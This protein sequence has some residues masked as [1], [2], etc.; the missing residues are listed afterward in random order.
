MKNITVDGQEIKNGNKGYEIF[1]FRSNVESVIW[2]LKEGS[3]YSMYLPNS[4]GTLTFMLACVNSGIAV[5]HSVRRLPDN[6]IITVGDYVENYGKILMI[7]IFD[8]Y[9]IA[10]ISEGAHI[11]DIQTVVKINKPESVNPRIS[12]GLK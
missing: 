2:E 11:L 6:E 8:P 5:V 1:S 10:L 12:V 7:T 3:Y 4:G 9:N